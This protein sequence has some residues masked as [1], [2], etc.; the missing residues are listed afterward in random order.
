MAGNSA[1]TQLMSLVER[2]NKEAGIEVYIHGDRE[3][4]NDWSNFP[5]SVRKYNSDPRNRIKIWSYMRAV[6]NLRNPET[7]DASNLGFAVYNITWEQS[8]SEKSPYV[9]LDVGFLPKVKNMDGAN[10]K[11]IGGSVPLSDLVIT[12]D[13]DV[14]YFT[15]LSMPCAI[16]DR[17]GRGGGGQP[18]LTIVSN[19][20]LYMALFKYIRRNPQNYMEI[21]RGV[22]PVEEFPN[23]NKGIIDKTHPFDTIRARVYNPTKNEYW[24]KIP[25]DPIR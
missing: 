21:V 4:L 17:G 20:D 10:R 5:D 23:V 7:G 2:I 3:D 14:A 1:D 24:F 15:R 11:I 6:R 19:P 22:L 12:D 13:K 9:A 16:P 8:P 18:T 25:G